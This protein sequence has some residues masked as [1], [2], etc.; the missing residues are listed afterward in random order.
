LRGRVSL[1]VPPAGRDSF[2]WCE[3]AVPRF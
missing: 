1:T 3:I 2:L